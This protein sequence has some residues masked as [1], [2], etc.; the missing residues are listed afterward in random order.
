MRNLRAAEV[1][2]IFDMHPGPNA[3]NET[4]WGHARDHSG[5]SGRRV[6]FPN[7]E[8][9]DHEI[10]NKGFNNR[11]PYAHVN[12]EPAIWALKQICDHVR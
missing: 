9:Q 2:R 8:R 1:T 4:H 12:P 10:R 6:C 7:V 5:S 3:N 11:I